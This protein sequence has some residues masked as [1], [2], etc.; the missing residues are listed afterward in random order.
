MI[1]KVSVGTRIASLRKRE[2]YSQA[3]FSEIL[4][5][6]PQAISKWETGASLPDIGILLDMSWI[7]KTSINSILEGDAYIEGAGDVERKYIFLNKILMCPQC[8]HGLKLQKMHAQNM[9]YQCD[10]GHAYSVI[11]GVLDFNTRE[12]P[13][14]L[15]SLSLRNYDGYL[16]MQHWPGNPNYRRGRNQADVIWKIIEKERPK[17]ILDMACGMGLGIQKQIERINWPATIIMVDVSHR[18]LK[19]NQVFYSTERRNPFVDMVYL[20]CDGANL[21]LMDN[22]VDM[23]FSYGGYESMQDKMI[24]G[25]R[26]AYRV[27]KPTGC[28]VYTKSIVENL[29]DP[30]SQRWMHLLLS[31]VGEEEAQWWKKEF[32]D[33]QQWMDTCRAIGFKNN[34]ST[35]IYGELPAPDTDTFPFENEMAQWMAEYVFVSSKE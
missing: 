15:W 30:N 16:Q 20:A 4:H 10:L 3:E 2:G 24:E 34:T 27:I 18:I 33:E 22:S 9:M 8:R 19:W 32:L 11:D 23:V 31:A 29:Q 7:F 25:V 1:D 21:P 6:S 12:I 35:K 28:S 26:E 13:G 5:V 14:E 17:V